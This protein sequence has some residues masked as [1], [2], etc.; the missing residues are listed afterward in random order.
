MRLETNSKSPSVVPGLGR[1]RH[2]R[3]LVSVPF[4]LRHLLPGGVR[5]SPGITLDIS[6][7]GIGALVQC[8]L[9]V[10]DTV[11]IDLKLPGDML[12][13]VA[14]VRHTSSVSSGFEFVGLYA[15]ER[16]QIANAAFSS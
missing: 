6:E 13:I 3:A 9:R 15:E 8:A 14:I 5:T 12:S 7:Q 10:G 11:E 2:R 16:S 4:A 1:R